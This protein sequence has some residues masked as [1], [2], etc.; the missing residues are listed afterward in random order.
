[1]VT[2]SVSSDRTQLA[3]TQQRPAVSRHATDMAISAVEATPR[4]G[5][6]WLQRRRAMDIALA[7]Y[8]A[9][10]TGAAT[11]QQALKAL[12]AQPV[13]TVTTVSMLD[14]LTHGPEALW[15]ITSGSPDPLVPGPLAWA[16]LG[17]L[18]LGVWAWLLTVNAAQLPGPVSVADANLGSASA[19]PSN[20]SKG[21][22]IDLQTVFRIAVLQNINEPGASPGATSTNP[23]TD[24]LGVAG[25]LQGF[26]AVVGVAMAIT[27]RR[28]GY[29]IDLDLTEDSTASP[30]TTAL[31]RVKTLSG[32]RTLASQ[33]IQDRTRVEA[34]SAGGLW[35]AGYVLN[36][37]TR[38]PTWAAWNAETA[39]ALAKSKLETL[40]MRELEAA[41]V[42]SHRVV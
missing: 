22:Q 18:A 13:Q 20:G 41:V 2:S 19:A 24:L 42:T 21:D 36:R 28:Y 34:V 38:I 5:A 15:R 14:A 4:D 3:P 1:V 7:S 6:D 32:D 11:D 12:E 40:S 16:I 39:E 33:V 23:V 10:V 27:G 37:S 26:A 9:Q 17:L 29:Q 35:A 25:S 31:V 8:K 30:P